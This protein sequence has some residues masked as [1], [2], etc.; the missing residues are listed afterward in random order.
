MIRYW[1]SE[2]LRTRGMPEAMGLL[3]QGN[4]QAFF[5]LFASQMP[6]MAANEGEC[7]ACSRNIKRRSRKRMPIIPT[8]CPACHVA[9][10]ARRL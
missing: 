10:V 5:K 2:F 7:S 6:E 3:H 8:R 1:R 4:R 9:T